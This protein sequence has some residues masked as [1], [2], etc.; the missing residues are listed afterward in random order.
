M[1]KFIKI[2]EEKGITLSPHQINQFQK[3][4]ECL[5]EWNEKMNL[6]AITDREQVYIKHFFDSL[7]PSFYFDL[8]PELTLCD[9][10]SGAGFPSIPL[11][12]LFPNLKIAI[13]DALK[14]RLTFLEA[15]AKELSLSDIKLYHDRAETFAKKPEIRESFDIVTARAVAKL[16]VLSEYCLPLT[17]INGTFIALKGASAEEEIEDSKKAIDILGGKIKDVQALLLPEEQSHR[18]LIFIDKVQKTPKKYP[19]KPGTP[20]KI[21]L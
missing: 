7:T 17:K 1:N 5:V 6:T 8:T 2:L 12:I 19:R 16:S 3:Y 10:G 20:S 4:Y 14:K 13:V 11:K 9:V 18:H 21:P 15:L